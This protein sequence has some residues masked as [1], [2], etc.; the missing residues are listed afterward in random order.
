MREG[1]E[2]E[3]PSGVLGINM[4]FGVVARMRGV[5]DCFAWILKGDVC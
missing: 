5:S 2:S 1:D 3:G 4:C